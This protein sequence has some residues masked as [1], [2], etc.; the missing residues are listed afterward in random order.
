MAPDDRG[1]KNGGGRSG[2]GSRQALKKGP[3]TAAEDAILVEYVKKHGEG[4]WNAV[5]R[6]SGL[7]RCGKSCRLRWANHLRPHLKKGGFSPEEERII[8]ELHAKLGN[9]WARMAAQLPGRT[10]NEIKN[11]WNTRLKRRQRAG[12]PIYPQEL[13]AQ[14]QQENN[15]PQNLISSPFDPQKATYNNP[16]SLS[17]SLLNIFNSSTMKPPI[18]HQFPLN[19]NNIF[20]DP[21]KGLSLTLPSSM[22]NSQFSSSVPNNN[23]G[24]G[25]SNSML[26]P[27]FQQQNYPN[28]GLTRPFMG[29]SSNQNELISGMG[30]N[31]INNYP[32]GQLSMPVTT[33]GSS[34]ENT[35]SDFG[36][37][38]ANN[39][40]NNIAG[41]SRGNSGLLEDLLEE[42]QIITR[43]VKIEDNNYVDLKEKD[44]NYKGKSLWEDYGLVEENQDEAVLTEESVYN[45]AHGGD[46]ILN[47]NSESSS[48]HPN[49]SSGILLQKEDSLQGIN[50]ADEDIMCLLDN[51]PLAVPVPD[52]YDERDDQKN[53]S[54]F[55][56]DDHRAEKQAEES[57]SQVVITSTSG[58]KKH[59][60]ELG[61]CCWNNMP[62]FC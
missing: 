12:L 47:N 21:P 55:G 20:R 4:N 35:G 50:Q 17:L 14:N 56:I 5:Q 40:A 44:D 52:W 41:L 38:D 25:L 23:F 43:A 8:I 45:F 16:S 30:I 54:K 61:G 6:N 10:D 34:S 57:K 53:N 24:H 42:S 7:M 32:S 46:V 62:S 36:S 1:M 3:W 18:T 15:Q 31:S 29:I 19:S 60:W 13:Q 26:V 51:F 59:D 9:K 37:S 33:T 11:Y 27:S 39:Y 48:P 49:S 58:S 22:R 2:G 28:F